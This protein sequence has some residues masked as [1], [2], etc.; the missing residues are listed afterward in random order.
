MGI[1]GKYPRELYR[2]Y[3]I[4]IPHNNCTFSF[5][6]LKL[7]SWDSEIFKVFIENSEVY[8]KSYSY[9]EGPNSICLSNY[10]ELI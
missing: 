7:D 8:S 2:T 6:F 10:Y 5:V 9:Y 3:N 1:L 4:T